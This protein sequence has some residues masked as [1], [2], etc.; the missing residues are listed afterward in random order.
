[1]ELFRLCFTL[2]VMKQGHIAG[3]QRSLLNGFQNFQNAFALLNADRDEIY[4]VDH[5]SALRYVP[6]MIV[7]A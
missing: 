6:E 3:I 1:M 4:I 5:F 7:F 2:R